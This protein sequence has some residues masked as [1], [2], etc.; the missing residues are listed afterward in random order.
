MKLHEENESFFITEDMGSEMAAAGY[1]F[2]LPARAKSIRD[3]YG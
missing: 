2:S 3:L 1:E